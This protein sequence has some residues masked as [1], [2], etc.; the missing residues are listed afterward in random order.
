MR[1]AQILKEGLGF[2]EGPRWHEGRLWLS[3]STNGTVWALDPD[4][5][6]ERVVAVPGQPS[7]LGWLPDGRLLVVSWANRR[8]MRLD[9]AGL[10]EHAD[11]GGVTTFHCNDMVVDGKGRAWVG[12][13][14][15]DFGEYLD[16]RGLLGVSAVPDLPTAAIARVDPDGA[17]HV[18]AT[19]LRFPNGTVVT[20]DGSMLVVAETFG[21][22]L[23]AFDIGA[24]GTLTNRRTWAALPG[25]VPD[26]IALDAEGAIW[27]A[28]PVAAECL[29][30]APGGGVLER[31]A[32]SQPC[33]ACA[34]G[35]PDRLTLFLLTN[36]PYDPA[37]HGENAGRV[38]T[39]PVAVPG[40]GW[41]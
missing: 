24:D 9:P 1:Q 37:G 27:V 4:A 18:A 38:E 19:G 16:G 34:L 39:V 11:L 35:G 15:F 10:V 41:P 40:A 3:D 26:G 20:P 5:G 25:V 32:T 2:V 29:R 28:N 7:G 33:Y 30:V 6:I 14:G 23:T 17:I 31:V 13:W 8:L 36:P 22:R 12:N 21:E